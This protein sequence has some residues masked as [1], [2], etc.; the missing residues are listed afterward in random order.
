MYILNTVIL[1]MEGSKGNKGFIFVMVLISMYFGYVANGFINFYNGLRLEYLDIVC[2]EMV[3]NKLDE[4]YITKDFNGAQLRTYTWFDDE[5]GCIYGF[6]RLD[7]FL[8]D[9]DK[10]YEV[11][12]DLIEYKRGRINN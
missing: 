7:E 4:I 11:F 9:Y 2:M 8:L 5:R 10:D 6:T 1:G 3:E 12:S